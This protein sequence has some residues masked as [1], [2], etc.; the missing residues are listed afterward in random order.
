MKT[1][2]TERFVVRFEAK[3]I[4]SWCFVSSVCDSFVSFILLLRVRLCFS[5]SLDEVKSVD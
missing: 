4:Y 3:V 1:S 2:E 5:V